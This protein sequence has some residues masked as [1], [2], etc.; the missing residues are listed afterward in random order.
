MYN[1]IMVKRILYAMH[2]MQGQIHLNII[3]LLAHDP[4]SSLAYPVITHTPLVTGSYYQ[5]T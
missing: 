5:I 1:I 4:L 3:I 2:D